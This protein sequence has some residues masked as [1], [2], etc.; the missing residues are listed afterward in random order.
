MAELKF[1]LCII[2]SFCFCHID[3]QIIQQKSMSLW[4]LLFSLCEVFK[5]S[6]KHSAASCFNIAQMRSGVLGKQCLLH[7]PIP[8][9]L[10]LSFQKSWRAG[11]PG[12]LKYTKLML[13]RPLYWM[14]KVTDT[15][16]NSTPCLTFPGSSEKYLN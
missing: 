14:P 3:I 11:I 6:C 4:K 12:Q 1:V 9:Q 8:T 5:S 15:C 10:H 7:M 2:L 13:W 16:V